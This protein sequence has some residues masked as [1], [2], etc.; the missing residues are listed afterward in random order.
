MNDVNSNQF[1]A[2]YII[3]FTFYSANVDNSQGKVKSQGKTSS[4]CQDPLDSRYQITN[5]QST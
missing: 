3:I 5:S 1:P 4:S 2:R